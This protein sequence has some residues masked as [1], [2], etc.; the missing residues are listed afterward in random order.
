MSNNWITRETEQG[1]RHVLPV[2]DLREHLPWRCWC[3][4]TPDAD[5]ELVI[6]HHALDKREEYE[7]GRQPS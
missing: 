7:K 2:G 4:P 1:Y 6:V 5:D 3:N